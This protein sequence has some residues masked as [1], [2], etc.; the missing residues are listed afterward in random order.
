M[1]I[2]HE[3][4]RRQFLEKP[5]EASGD[6]VAQFD[7]ILSA[8]GQGARQ[9][10]EEKGTTAQLSCWRA[11]DAGF[12]YGNLHPEVTLPPLSELPLT[13]LVEACYSGAVDSFQGMLAGAHS[14]RTAP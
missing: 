10:T 9:Y 6:A 4:R 14:A 5:Y 11:L 3:A 12:V 13:E 2:L 1:A 8:A 7:A